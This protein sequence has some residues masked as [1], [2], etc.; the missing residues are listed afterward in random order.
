MQNRPD[1]KV[2]RLESFLLVWQTSIPSQLSGFS[3]FAWSVRTYYTKWWT[4]FSSLNKHA[5]GEKTC[6]NIFSFT[7]KLKFCH[8][9]Y[10]AHYHILC[11]DAQYIT[12]WERWKF[13]WTNMSPNLFAQCYFPCEPVLKYNHVKGRKPC[14]RFFTPNRVCVF[15]QYHHAR[16]F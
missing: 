13:R 8:W 10:C 15:S 5:H 3:P 11:A 7:D 12:P 1:E 6:S 14:A 16:V 4:C 9:I 2:K